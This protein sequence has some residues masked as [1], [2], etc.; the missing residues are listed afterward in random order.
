MYTID[1]NVLNVEFSDA[2]RLITISFVNDHDI[3]HNEQVLEILGVK[4]TSNN[5]EYDLTGNFSIN[6]NDKYLVFTEKD[7]K[8][9]LLP[10]FL[11]VD[12]KI[13]SKDEA[14]LLSSYIESFNNPMKKNTI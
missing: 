3:N 6:Y 13:I 2:S 14:E 12:Y 9:N 11:S 7:A 5:N 10:R 1:T 8:Y 4:Q